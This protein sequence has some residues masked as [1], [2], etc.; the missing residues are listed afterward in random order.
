V[1]TSIGTKQPQLNGTGFVKVTGTTV[2]YD[3]ATYLT[4]GTASS[5]YLPLAGGTLTGALAGTTSAWNGY[6]INATPPSVGTAQTFVRYIN[7]GS[8]WYIGSESSIAGGFFAGASAYASV[9]FGQNPFQFITGGVKRFEIATGGITS[10]V[11]FT[12]TSATFSG[13]V[14]I[15]APIS[16][17][18]KL[19][20]GIVGTDYSWLEY[21]DATGNIGYSSKYSH[22]FYGGGV[23]TTQILSLANNGVATFSS[24]II[25]G[26]SANSSSAESLFLKGKAITSGG[27]G[28]YGDYGSIVL[29][30][31]SSYTSGAR[32]YLI[33]SAYSSNRFGIIQSVDSTTTPTLG[34]AG[35][36][37]SGNLIF[38]ILNT[39][40]AVFS[41]PLSGTSATFSSTI[42]AA[43]GISTTGSFTSTVSGTSE[44]RL[45]GGAYGGNY[46][47]SLRSLAGAVGVLQFGNNGENYVLIG[48]TGI[49]SNTYLSFRIN[50]TT[51]AT[52]SG[53]EAFRIT[54]SGVGNSSTSFNGT[55]AFLSSVSIGTNT[56]LQTST[57]RTVLTIN[58]VSSNVLNFGIGGTLSGY[59]YNDA[60]TTGI[61]AQGNLYLQAD[62]ANFTSFT[63]NS[64]ERMRISN[65]GSVFYK[66]YFGS[67]LMGGFSVIGTLSAVNTGNRYLHVKINTIANMMYWIKIFGYVY[68]TTIIEGMS[69]GY[70]GGGTGAVQQTFANGNIVTQYQNNGF[71]EIVV[72]TINTSTT[73]RWGSITFLGGTDTIASVIP[74]EIMAYSWTASTT[75]VY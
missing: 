8:D 41:V 64:L 16:G 56:L 43:G 68:T 38:H 53:T 14:R 72:D 25:A 75:M 63:N 20:F 55:S 26:N 2:S 47:T 29:S 70:I 30:A 37:S 32:R 6:A 4:T 42:S 11:G 27:A 23:G 58:G 52:S 65:V 34:D 61:Y 21:N 24:T 49:S 44:L 50:C 31:D 66:G 60:A 57:N 67:N 13:N 35:A 46:N 59:I 73:N 1:A 15:N 54:S 39:G 71:L 45:Q 33:T 40:A 22:I 28:P 69:G 17:T 19:I 62:G 36:I 9:L 5:T 3:N 12:G 10:T 74:L 51:E 18:N 48:N 7:A